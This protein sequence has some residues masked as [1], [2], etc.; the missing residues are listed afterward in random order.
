[1]QFQTFESISKKS[2]GTSHFRRFY[3]RAP[4]LVRYAAPHKWTLTLTLS[5]FEKRRDTKRRTSH[6]QDDDTQVH[7]PTIQNHSDLSAVLFAS[8]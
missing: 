8:D 5:I 7:Q 4:V 2:W 3:A 1:M 6:L